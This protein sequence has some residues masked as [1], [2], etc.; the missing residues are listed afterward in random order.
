MQRECDFYENGTVQTS[1]GGEVRENVTICALDG[2]G[3]ITIAEGNFAFTSGGS[4]LSYASIISL[5]SG[6]ESGEG[7]VAAGP[8]YD[9]LP[10]GATSSPPI[11][12]TMTFDTD[13]WEALQGKDLV[14]LQWN[15]DTGA[16][17]Q[18]LSTIDGDQR[19]ISGKIARFG[20]VGL[21]EQIPPVPPEGPGEGQVPG[22]VSGTA[23][24]NLLIPLFLA[25]CLLLVILAA[26]WWSGRSQWRGRPSPEWMA[27][28][29]YQ[30]VPPPEGASEPA[31]FSMINVLNDI[32]AQL[33]QLEVTVERSGAAISPQD[34]S[35]FVD[36]FFYSTQVA[37]E[38][39]KNPE[40]RKHLTPE[41]IDQ[42]N[43]QLQNAVQKMIALSQQ[44]TSLQN[45]VQ[46]R[47]GEAKT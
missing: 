29:G 27:G 25:F 34:A 47:Y 12:L 17:D 15:A 31:L 6:V 40:M 37:E 2:I 36:K 13:R 24:F 42:L 43:L 32:E 21:F 1:L 28:G 11:T 39:I 20:Q 33:K 45:A 9:L 10:G 23:A 22:E 14:L 46:A 18:V 4:P 38:R 8:R 41:Q 5:V 44:S 19:T 7:F 35:V 30:K 26:I 3:K 16:W